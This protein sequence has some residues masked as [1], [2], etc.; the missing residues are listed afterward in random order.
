VDV[1]GRPNGLYIAGDVAGVLSYK[2]ISGCWAE[3][4]ISGRSALRSIQEMR[5]RELRKIESKAEFDRVYA[6]S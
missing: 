2:F 5:T 6:L 1:S 3:G 4:V